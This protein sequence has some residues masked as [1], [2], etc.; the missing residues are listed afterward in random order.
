MNHPIAGGKIQPIHLERKVYV[1]IRQSTVHQVQANTGSTERQYLLKNGI[2]DLGWSADQ[3]VVIDEDQARSGSSM[4]GR[5]GFKALLADVAAG[6][7]GAVCS[8]EVSRLARDSADWQNLLKL[9]RFTNTLVIDNDAVYNLQDKNDR[10]IL[11]IKGQMSEIELQLITD[12]LHGAKRLKAEKGEL[13]L[14][15]PTGL[16]Y[17]RAGKVILEPNEEVRDRVQLAFELLEQLGSASAVIKHFERNSL[18]F[19][20][21]IRSGDD[22]GDYKWKPLSLGRLL[23]ILHNPAYAGAYVYGRSNQIK[24][25]DPNNSYDVISYAVILKRE[26]W[27]IIRLG[28]HAGYISWEQ[29]LSNQ[30]LLSNNTNTCSLGQHGAA[31]NGSALLQG[32]VVCGKCDQ[33]MDVAYPKDSKHPW[34]ICH[35]KYIKFGKPICQSIPGRSIN[36]KVTQEF[37]S[38][39]NQKNIEQALSSLENVEG[40]ADRTRMQWEL[41]IKKAERDVQVANSHLLKTD[42][43]DDLVTPYLR[44]QLREKLAALKELKQKAHDALSAS[45]RRLTETDRI[46]IIALAQDVHTLWDSEK[47]TNIVRKQALRC[48]V[49]RIILK[50]EAS[51]VGVDIMWTTG[52][53]HVVTTKIPRPGETTK[54]D[55]KTVQII[56]DMA[57][58]YTDRQ[59]AEQLNEMGFKTKTERSFNKVRVRTVRY[60]HNIPTECTEPIGVPP[61]TPMAGGYFPVNYVARMFGVSVA[62]VRDW[63]RSGYVDYFVN[64]ATK[65]SPLQIKI[66]PETPNKLNELISPRRKGKHRIYTLPKTIITELQNV[67]PSDEPMKLVS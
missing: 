18:L 67:R 60:N 54:T 27:A 61:S 65:R 20:V 38:V 62:A 15:L 13:T 25:L 16:V 45:P 21:L 41:S 10:L 52:L 43:S 58:N 40:Q 49:K 22:K 29:F 36:D 32:L 46:A 23:S 56:R 14:T 8:L 66:T 1:Y 57:K 39:V 28:S 5:N 44:E 12:R 63:C 55:E 50:R 64:G 7:V 47:M 34:Y 11:G 19:P 42:P 33:K 24:K 3:V 26:D 48:V 37:L 53:H 30:R 6:E 31:R 51:N 35:R 17:N 4:A 9:C 59:I 2:I